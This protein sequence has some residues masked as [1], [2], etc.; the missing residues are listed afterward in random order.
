MWIFLISCWLSD[1]VIQSTGIYSPLDE[2]TVTRRH[3]G[4]FFAL[5]SFEQQVLLF[6]G[7]NRRVIAPK[8]PGPGEIQL[9]NRVLIQGEHLFIL[10]ASYIHRFDTQGIFEHRIHLPPGLKV[11]RAIN[12]WVGT[13]VDLSKKETRISL[14]DTN[15]NMK[16]ELLVWAYD[17]NTRIRIRPGKTNT[18]PIF[19]DTGDQTVSKDGTVLA[20][21]A[22][23]SRTIFNLN[24]S[25][26][27]VAETMRFEERMPF[28]KT[29][30][31][32]RLQTL[33]A[34]I[35]NARFKAVF[36]ENF[37]PTS[38][39]FLDHANKL[40]I[41]YWTPQGARTIACGIDGT[42]VETQLDIEQ[43]KRIIAIE[44]ENYYVGFRDPATEEMGIANVRRDRILSFLSDNPFNNE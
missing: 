6:T 21:R 29:I 25:N 27:E 24:L 28:S 40:F 33:R 20:Y 12:G 9:P 19:L 1:I 41:Q 30:G 13:K 32:E 22:P 43:R 14:Y 42:R 44:G 5:D 23:G 17:K 7:K 2:R 10:T 15:L 18:I 35:P 16:K 36:P 38:G 4:A 37:P 8:G 11:Q 3:D 39:L 26:M 31:E 34:N